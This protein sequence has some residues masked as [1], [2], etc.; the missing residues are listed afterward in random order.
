MLERYSHIRVAARRDAV[1][2][3]RLSTEDCDSST[4]L[5][6]FHYSDRRRNNS[7]EANQERLNFLKKLVSAVGIEPTT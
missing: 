2:A 4:S 7:G 6:R 5:Y 1:E 3:L